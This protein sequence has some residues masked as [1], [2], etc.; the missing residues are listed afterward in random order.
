MRT[1]TAIRADRDMR[2]DLQSNVTHG[3]YPS[4]CDMHALL[5]RAGFL[6]RKR[7]IAVRGCTHVQGVSS[8]KENSEYARRL[9]TRAPKTIRV[10]VFDMV[11]GCLMR[12]F[13]L[14]MSANHK[15]S[16]WVNC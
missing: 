10:Q 2:V 14:L 11:W 5:G 12:G 16:F 3:Q 7:S 6:S 1:T 15:P 4:G 8:C 9:D 13:A